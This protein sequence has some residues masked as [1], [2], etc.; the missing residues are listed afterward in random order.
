MKN[1]TVLVTGGCGFIGSNL[2]PKLEALGYKVNILDNLSK[3]SLDY[4][5]KTNAKIFIGDIRDRK[6]V[7]EA[8]IGVSSVIHLAAYGSVVESVDDPVENFD[9]NVTG[10]FTVLDECRKACVKKIIFSST[11]GALIGNALPPVDETSIPKPISPY[12]SSKLCC[13]AYCSS[14][15]HSYNMDITAL[16][17]ANVVGPVSWHKKGAVTAF[18]K[19]IMDGED[20]TIYGN[21]EATRD[22]LYVDDLCQGI[23]KTLQTSL[24]GF[25]PIHL[26]SGKE[27]SVSELATLICRVAHSDNHPIVY[28]DKRIGEVERNFANYSLAKELIDFHPKTSLDKA[29]KLTWD[30][31][32]EYNSKFNLND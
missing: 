14:F 15:S 25:Q 7:S 10:S 17:F 5:E 24:P 30:W 27:V 3:G 9:I 23:I 2:V 19:S 12:G 28:C 6:I 31:F 16:R 32:E 18:M 11:G 20:I 13:E 21:G 4:V 29:I 26:A 1:K 8:L 22:F